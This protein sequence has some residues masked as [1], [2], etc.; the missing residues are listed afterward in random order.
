VSLRLLSLVLVALTVV[1]A[2]GAQ[3]RPAQETK[4]STYVVKHAAAKDLAG[5]LAKHFKGAAEIQAGP[6]GTSNCL[7]INAPPAVCRPM[8]PFDRARS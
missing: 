4:R 8:T 2:T 1:A 7:L 3:E 5:I 6:E